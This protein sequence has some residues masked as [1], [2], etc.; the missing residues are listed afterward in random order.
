MTR[1][2]VVVDLPFMSYQVSVE[3][4]MRAAGRVLKESGAHAVKLEGGE[5]VAP[6][7]RASDR[8]RASR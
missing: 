7:V 3:D 1:A 5:E 6:L 2:H 4:G 8:G